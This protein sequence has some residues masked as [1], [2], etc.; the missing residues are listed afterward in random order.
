MRDFTVK[1]GVMGYIVTIGCQSAGFSN[2]QDLL[3]AITEYISD[4]Q[5]TEKKYYGRPTD[6]LTEVDHRQYGVV[7]QGAKTGPFYGISRDREILSSIPTLA[8]GNTTAS[9]SLAEDLHNVYTE[10]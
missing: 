9:Q 4:P 3:A 8:N 10:A 5:A 2:K 7:Q 1:K 6:T